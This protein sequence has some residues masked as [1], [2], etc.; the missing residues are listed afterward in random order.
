[1]SK[2]LKDARDLVMPS[3]AQVK[4]MP[5]QLAMAGATVGVSALVMVGALVGLKRL[6][7]R[8]SAEMQTPLLYV[9]PVVFAVLAVVLDSV[10][11]VL[12][13]LAARQSVQAG[14]VV[15]SGLKRVVVLSVLFVA[16][17]VAAEY[18]GDALGEPV[19]GYVGP[20][21]MNMAVAA[22]NA[23]PVNS[24]A[25]NAAA[26]NNAAPMV[27]ANNNAALKSAVSDM[28]SSQH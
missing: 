25:N 11:V 21:A 6:Q 15:V 24:G 8:Q 5:R 18:I 16:V 4:L 1:M 3:K 2:L 22:P 26:S 12:G 14:P 28:P 19:D 13:R 20:A 7:A 27:A 23:P 9:V 17:M 10:R